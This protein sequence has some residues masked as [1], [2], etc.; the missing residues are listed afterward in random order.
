MELS[1][2]QDVEAGDGTTSVVVLA[3][4]FLDA[5]QKLLDKG[6]HPTVISEAFQRASAKAVDILVSIAT[7][8]K[9]D[10]RQS[11]LQA[12][13]TSLGSKVVSQHSS[14]LAPLAVDAVLK[15][16]TLIFSRRR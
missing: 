12:A 6:I 2:A 4:S 14:L 1:K 3:G 13:T 5:A 15:V 8:L 16:N 11:L 7:P 9:L 10:D